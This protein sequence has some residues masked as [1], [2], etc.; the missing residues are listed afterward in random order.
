MLLLFTS[1]DSQCLMLQTY[2]VFYLLQIRGKIQIFD[3]YSLLKCQQ[4]RDKILF[5]FLSSRVLTGDAA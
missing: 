4:K 5:D 2:N 3:A 1:E